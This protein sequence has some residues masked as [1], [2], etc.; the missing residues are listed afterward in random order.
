MSSKDSTLQVAVREI[1]GSAR[2]AFCKRADCGLQF[3]HVRRIK[4]R[5]TTPAAVARR[6]SGKSGPYPTP[7]HQRVAFVRAVRACY[8][9]CPDCHCWYDRS[10]PR[11]PIREPRY[12]STQHLSCGLVVVLPHWGN[13]VCETPRR[14]ALGPR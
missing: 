5:G 10:K 13:P 2:C 11:P 7:S 9:L 4:G 1:K 8:M 14:V 12:W 3:A 6:A